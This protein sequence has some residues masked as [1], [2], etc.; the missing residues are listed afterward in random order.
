MNAKNHLGLHLS[1]RA[2]WLQQQ[3]FAP[4]RCKVKAHVVPESRETWAPHT[5]IGFYIGNAMEH[6]HCHNVYISDTKGTHVCSS[7]FFKH[8]YLT[9]PTLTPSDALIKAADIVSEAITGAIPVSSITN[10]AITQ[11]LTIFK[12]QANSAKDATSGQ[13]VLTQQAQSQRV[14]TE[15]S[16]TSPNQMYPP[17]QTSCGWIL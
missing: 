10:D 2:T 8:K 15:K 13:R 1:L 12:Q 11:L 3:P 9:M 16:S 4:L 5:A 17:K 7:I 14:R 6:Y